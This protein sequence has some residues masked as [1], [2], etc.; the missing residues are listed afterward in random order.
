MD[1]KWTAQHAIAIPARVSRAPP[2]QTA[3]ADCLDR[4]APTPLA[5]NDVGDVATR[6]PCC[7]SY[8]YSSS[9]GPPGVPEVLSTISVKKKL[10]QGTINICACSKQCTFSAQYISFERQMCYLLCAYF[11]AGGTTTYRDTVGNR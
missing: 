9:D 7:F 6:A 2:A 1:G 5:E 8:F 4:P 3:H 11:D 10:L